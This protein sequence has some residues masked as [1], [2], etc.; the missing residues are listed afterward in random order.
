MGELPAD[1]ATA[2]RL[3]GEMG[4]RFA[5]YDWAGHPLG[6]ISGWPPAYRSA[7][8]AALSSRFPIVLWL[9]AQDLYLVYN[10]GDLPMLGEKHPSALGS[11]GREVW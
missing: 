8:T 6:P 1:L 11:P 9:G 7:V 4:R 3:G 2:V 10:D 5:A